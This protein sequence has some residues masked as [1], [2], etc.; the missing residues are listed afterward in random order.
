MFPK[1]PCNGGNSE[2][3]TNI[4]LPS[5][6]AVIRALLKYNGALPGELSPLGSFA[7][8]DG[9]S[10]GRLVQVN[11]AKYGEHSD[12][13]N[14]PDKIPDDILNVL[15]V[16]S[17]CRYGTYALRVLNGVPIW[18]CP[19]NHISLRANSDDPP[20]GKIPT[21]GTYSKEQ[22][23]LIRLLCN[24]PFM[25]GAVEITYQRGEPVK[26]YCVTEDYLRINTE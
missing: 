23:G 8:S 13:T 17:F 10:M 2:R 20:F 24:I 5:A 22:K 15:N 26:I 21:G 25:N 12:S 9:A 3:V 16:I 11:P 7:S 6:S 1:E 19:I 18:N 14:A 4:Y